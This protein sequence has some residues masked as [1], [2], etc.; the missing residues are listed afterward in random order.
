VHA[1]KK[2]LE[3]VHTEALYTHDPP[4]EGMVAKPENLF[5]YESLF[6]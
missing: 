3:I 6:A 1:G 5:F 4:Y 2:V